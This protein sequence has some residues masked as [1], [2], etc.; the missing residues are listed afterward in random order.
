MAPL[1]DL[2]IP[3]ATSHTI[4]LRRSTA[5]DL[6]QRHGNAT[7][8]TRWKPGEAVIL[9]A[10]IPSF[11]RSSSPRD[12][13]LVNIDPAWLQR[14]GGADRR[15]KSCFGRDDPVLAGLSQVLLA[16]LD[17]NTSLS[18]SFSENIALA[19]ALHLLENYAEPSADSP[20]V[21]RLSL[22]QMNMLRDALADSFH[23]KWPVARL[24]HLVGLSPYHFSRAFKASFGTPPHAYV[25]LQRMEA[26]A[27]LL[28]ATREPLAKIAEATGYPSAAHF[29]HAFRRRWGL[30]PTAFRSGR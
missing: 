5:T 1:G 26:A 4:L 13:V 14:A 24:A 12:N 3:A 17:N 8:A 21:V 11:W 25:S 2:Y 15:L 29:A 10:G 6:L 23:E 7:Q 22:R 30:T 19:I 9:P 16:S 20:A 18:T 28:R 27:R